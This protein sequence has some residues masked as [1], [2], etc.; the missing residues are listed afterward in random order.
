MIKTCL[1]QSY[2][3][4]Y[5]DGIVLKFVENT[6]WTALRFRER[7]LNFFKLKLKFRKGFFKKN[8]ETYQVS[9]IRSFGDHFFSQDVERYAQKTNTLFL[10]STP[11]KKDKKGTFLKMAETPD[12]TLDTSINYVLPRP[13]S[14]VSGGLI[15][16]KN[17]FFL[18]FFLFY[19]IRKWIVLTKAARTKLTYSRYRC[20]IHRILP[21]KNKKRSN[22]KLQ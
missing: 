1:E 8:R 13:W 3:H 9:V 19:L 11:Q 20:R 18:F 5:K 4:D 16:R 21:S 12:M 22:R 10:V 17:V 7:K 6:F 2:F 14:T 15:F